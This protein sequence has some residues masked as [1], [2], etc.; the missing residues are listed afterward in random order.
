[1]TL[2][3]VAEDKRERVAQETL[4]LYAPLAGRMGMQDMREELEELAFRQLMPEAHDTI[5]GRLSEIGGRN[6]AAIVGI[7][8]ALAEAMRARGLD[9]QVK[10][11][12][13]KPYS[14]WR[15]MNSKS[16]ALEQLSD[17]F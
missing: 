5:V 3:F 6:E 16:I 9:V 2:H 15:K 10:G 1:R 4:D 13:K 14:V 11:R 8:A 7:E 12:M 17:I